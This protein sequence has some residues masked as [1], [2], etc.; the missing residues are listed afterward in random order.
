MPLNDS[1]PDLK[2]N[3]LHDTKTKPGERPRNWSWVTDLSLHE[4][5]LH[6]VRRAA[7]ARWR[8]EHETLK[9]VKIDGDHLNT[10]S[11]METST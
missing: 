1:H 6:D 5:N 10:I 3:V 2:V 8:I 11:A 4:E 9:T 7:R